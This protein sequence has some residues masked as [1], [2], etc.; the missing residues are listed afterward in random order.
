MCVGD[1]VDLFVVGF[2]VWYEFVGFLC[3]GCFGWYGVV[4]YCVCVV[5]VYVVL[6][7]D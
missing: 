5:G 4:W 1:F 6:C 2:V 7:C 3:V